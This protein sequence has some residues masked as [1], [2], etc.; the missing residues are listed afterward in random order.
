MFFVLREPQL[1]PS[2]PTT[3]PSSPTRTAPLSSACRCACTNACAGESGVNGVC[4]DA[5]SDDDVDEHD[6][7]LDDGGSDGYAAAGGIAIGFAKRVEI[8]VGVGIAGECVDGERVEGIAGESV[9]GEGMEGVDGE[10]TGR[11]SSSSASAM[12]KS[13]ARSCRNVA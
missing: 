4:G 12:P 13:R 2:R 8:G 10:G 1:R 3:A 6:E 9:D 11:T 5:D 7:P